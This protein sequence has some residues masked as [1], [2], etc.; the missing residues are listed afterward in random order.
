MEELTEVTQES[1]RGLS[2]D[3]VDVLR[4]NSTSTTPLESTYWIISFIRPGS[5]V[6]DIGCGTG[7]ITQAILK[8]RQVEIIGIEPNKER[9]EA[10]QK[11]GLRVLNDVYTDEFA[12][13]YGKFDYIVF[14]DVLEHLEDPFDLLV[15]VMKSLSENGRVIASVP[16]VAHWSV[17]LSLLVGRFDYAPTG[18]MDAT[19]LRWFTR[20][21]LVRLFMTAGYEVVE[22]RHSAGAWL[23]QYQ[24]APLRLL[25]ESYRRRLISKL[26]QFSHGL[27]ACQHVVSARRAP[28]VSKATA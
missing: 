15:K 17:R 5:R 10:A 1:F 12:G 6:L 21:S 20:E 24:W 26:G 16:N 18:I 8:E 4:Y 19:H 23:P 11:L 27:F 28:S 13:K 7:S 25:P 2:A 3:P 22:M 9:A 14:A